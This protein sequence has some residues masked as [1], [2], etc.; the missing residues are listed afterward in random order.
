[1]RR[2]VLAVCEGAML[3]HR[4]SPAKRVLL[5]QPRVAAKE[6]LV[7]W[8]SQTTLSVD[9]PMATAERLRNPF[10]SQNSSN[11]VRLVE[12]GKNS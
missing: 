5:A 12:V 1:M 6:R 3:S 4:A 10:P 11:S 8:L 2:R 7:V 9:E